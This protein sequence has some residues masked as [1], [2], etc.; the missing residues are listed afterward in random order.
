MLGEITVHRDCPSAGLAGRRL[1]RY[2]LLTRLA[3][4]G[5]ASIYVARALGVAGFERLVA[6]KILHPHIA[7]EREFI[8]MFLDE[9]R[10]AARIHHTNVVSTIDIDDAPDTGFYL[11]MDYIPGDHLGA[12]MRGAARSGEPLPVRD[13]LRIAVDALAGLAAAHELRDESGQRLNLVHRD[14]SPQNILVGTDGIARLTDFGVARAENRISATR[15][16]QFKGKLCYMA[17]EQASGGQADQR[18]DLFSMGIILWECLT[19]RRLFR[20]DNPAATLSMVCREPIA[21]PSCFDAGL[22]RFDPIL[23]QALHRDVE[24]RFGSAVEFA[25][26]IEKAAEALGGLGSRRTVS[27]LVEK[28]ASEKLAIERELIG[29]AATSLDTEP[30]SEDTVNGVPWAP[31]ATVAAGTGPNDGRARYG[32]RLVRTLGGIGLGIAIGVA[33]AVPAFLTKG[34]ETVSVYAVPKSETFPATGAVEQSRFLSSNVETL[35][36]DTDGSPGGVGLAADGCLQLF[37]GSPQSTAE[38][39]QL[40]RCLYYQD[41]GTTETESRDLDDRAGGGRWQAS[42]RATSASGEIRAVEKATEKSGFGPSRPARTLSSVPGIPDNPFELPGY[43]APGPVDG[44]APSPHSPTAAGIP[45]NPFEPAG[46]GISSSRGDPNG[47]GSFDP[48]LPPDGI[49]ANPF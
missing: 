46:S 1:G 25:D 29:A 18:S 34:G 38:E 6:V 48:V 39:S 49:P 9:A 12:L 16:G 33:F 13:A 27:N 23:A 47:S 44:P 31:D 40:A 30:E 28:H 2:Q 24:R 26:A 41:E 5:M 35:D 4:G 20:G 14:V 43:R 7:H 19:G 11:V 3:V 15:D 45:E 10:L 17:P 37:E 32:S 21:P 22:A 42:A 36:G 8:A